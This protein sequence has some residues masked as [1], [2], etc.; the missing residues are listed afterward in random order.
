[1]P[2]TYIGATIQGHTGQLDAFYLRIVDSTFPAEF[3]TD[4]ASVYKPRIWLLNPETNFYVVT[5]HPSVTDTTVSEYIGKHITHPAIF[6]KQDAAI[7]REIT[8]TKCSLQMDTRSAVEDDLLQE[9]EENNLTH[10][11]AC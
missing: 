4:D 9:E 6:G 8:C 5:C 10:R 11:T 1:M 7:E 3:K 2:L